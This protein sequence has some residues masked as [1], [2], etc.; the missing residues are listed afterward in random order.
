MSA[1]NNGHHE[2]VNA[3]INTGANIHDKNKVKSKVSSKEC[4]L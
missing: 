1:A 3:L 4:I 2:V